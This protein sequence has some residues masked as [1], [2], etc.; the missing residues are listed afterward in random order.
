MDYCM[1]CIKVLTYTKHYLD[2]RFDEKIQLPNYL[3]ARREFIYFIYSLFEFGRKSQKRGTVKKK[4][5]T[6]LYIPNK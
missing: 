6:G 2:E 3:V 4:Q 1:V 5:C